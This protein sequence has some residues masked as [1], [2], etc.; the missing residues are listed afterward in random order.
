MPHLAFLFV[1]FVWGGSFILMDRAGQAFGPVA[2]AMGRMAGGAAALI[3]YCLVKRAWVKLAPR[4]FGH[5]AVVAFLANV[6]PYVVQPY[7]MRQSGEH[8]FIGMMVAF[9]PLATIVV[10]IPMLGLWPAPRQLVGVLGGLACFGLLVYDGAHRGMSP[11]LLTLAVSS[12]LSYALGNTYIKWKLDHLPAAPLTATFLVLGAASL[13]PL[14]LAPELLHRWRLSPPALPHDLPQAA[15]AL[16][17]L[18]VVG[19]GICVLVFV[20]LIKSQGPLFAGMVTYVIPVVALLWGQY[21]RE[22]LTVTQIAAIAGVLAMVAL[23]QWRA[24]TPAELKELAP[25]AEPPA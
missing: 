6:W 18:G 24:S 22:R 16:L 4:D 12:P 21:D 8:G 5:L 10:S 25:T 15:A 19:T 9:V 1:C 3:L 13:V 7:V 17:T 11:L 14:Q 20:Q 23:V 2:I